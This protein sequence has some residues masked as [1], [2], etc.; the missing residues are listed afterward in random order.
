MEKVR[1][2]K[3]NEVFIGIE[4]E[5]GIEMELSEHFTFFVPG[6]KFMPA[7]RNKMWDGK[8][9][10][11]DTRKKETYSG[12]YKYIQEFCGQRGYE[13]IDDIPVGERV[14]Y[15][16][17]LIT[18]PFS[19]RDYQEKA[20]Q[21]IVQNKQGLLLS[22]TGSG[23]SLIIYLLTKFYL[24]FS[25]DK[26]VLII[27]PTTS[28]VE[29]MSSDFEAYSASEELIDVHKIYSGKEKQDIR[30][31]VV[32]TTWQSIYKMPPVWF[33][34]YGMVIGD[35][36]HTFKAKSLTSIMTKCINAEYRIG[37]TG[38]LDGTETHQLVL[39]GLF[40][41]VFRV[42]TTKDLM[43]SDTLAELK[44]NVLLL[45]YDEK[46]RSDN[47]NLDYQKEVDLIVTNEKR[48][49]FITNLVAEQSGNTLLLFQYVDKH[50]KVLYDIL[51]NKIDP[52]RK[53]FFISGSTPVDDREKMRGITE[54]EKNAIV[55]ASS[56]TFSTG[57]NIR[58][59]HNIVFASPSKSQIKI[60]QSIGRGLRKSD[61]GQPTTLYDIG[62]DLHWKTK[63]NYTLQH[64]GERIK[65]YSKEQFEFN[66]YEIDL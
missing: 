16:T 39:E 19:I 34:D 33:R 52:D 36:A 22:P 15:D 17:S 48:N 45:K 12:L 44:I 64:L 53:L 29:Q 18:L 9:R 24:D 6:Y 62:D 23:K 43:D 5:A 31:R 25:K 4:T 57:I 58:N 55:V 26:N 7:Y 14:F 51:K 47:K 41:P 42:T 20:V 63:K 1:V 40:G 54:K 46:Y 2:Y 37:T 56:G 38:T 11:Y 8:I 66:I 21:H 30:S 65:I 13:L 60:L 3:K 27:V 50:G 49:K 28:L 10:L 61:N 35:E 32:I 59:L